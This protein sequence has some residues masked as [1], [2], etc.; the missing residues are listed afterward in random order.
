MPLNK[1]GEEIR[2]AMRKQY[3]AEKG[4]RIF[5]ASVNSGKI[6][7][8][9]EEIAADNYTAPYRANRWGVGSGL[10][11]DRALL[12]VSR[13]C[14]STPV[15]ALDRSSVRAYDAN[16][17][18]HIG[19]SKATVNPYYGREIPKYKELGLDPNKIYR[20]FRDPSE[21]ERASPTFN[22]LPVL[23]S[24]VPV[25]ADTHRH[26]LV[27]GSLGTDSAF[28]APY[29]QNSLVIWDGKAIE[30]V[31]N[32]EKRELSCAYR[33]DADMTPGVYEGQAYDGVMRNII[34]NH[35]ALVR[36]GR[37][38][39]DV[40]IGDEQPIIK[41]RS[42]RFTPEMA[43]DDFEETSH[44]RDNNG[45]FT[46]NKAQNVAHAVSYL[47]SKGHQA[48]SYSNPKSAGAAYTNGKKISI[49]GAHKIWRDPVGFMEMHGKSGHLSSGH[50]YH[51]LEHEIGHAL[52]DPPN[53]FMTLSH[54]D[55]ARTVSKYAAMNPKE[56][57]AE[58]HAGMVAG[59]K[60]PENIMKMFNVYAKKRSDA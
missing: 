12:G 49:N 47:Q 19:I 16:N 18:L 4:D 13:S 10:A 55:D 30:G 40:V 25:S 60:Y 59:K 34:G 52:Y 53:N 33:Y 46:K 23:S 1:K 3:G 24:H 9:D 39:S 26:E 41:L 28:N 57:V 44:P 14:I 11:Q 48:E 32:D 21:L 38:G 22:N 8:V 50:A 31:E 15:F 36:Q 54:Q 27:M 37:A 35:V 56:F 51:L 17:W 45:K 43:A 20:L 2:A 58:V 7:G 5:Y 6:T 29:L 42:H